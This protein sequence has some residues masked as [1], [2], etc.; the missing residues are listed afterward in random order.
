MGKTLGKNLRKNKKGSVT[1]LILI[2]VILLFFGI[3]LLVGYK[4]TT[5]INTHIQA[6]NDLPTEAKTASTTLVSYY[7][8]IMDNVFLFLTIGLAIVSFVLAALVRIH[9]IF[10]PFFIIALIFLIFLSGVASNVYQEMSADSNLVTQANNLTFIT[11]ILE[12]LPLIV[13]VFGT[14]LMVVM[15]KTWSVNL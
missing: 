6:N 8:G 12:Y 15:Y 1:D 4:I 9:P 2:V 5:E 10:I 11:Y 3:V 7:P 13:G 14:I